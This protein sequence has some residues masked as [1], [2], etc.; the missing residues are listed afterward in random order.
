MKNYL[1][2]QLRLIHLLAVQQ[3][4]TDIQACDMWAGKGF[5]RMFFN[6]NKNLQD[7]N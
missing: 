6:T 3:N 4:I 1:S 2:K 5:D 7:I